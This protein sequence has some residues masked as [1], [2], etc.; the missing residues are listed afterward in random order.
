MFEASYARVYGV[1]T[2]VLTVLALLPHEERGLSVWNVTSRDANVASLGRSSV[3][4]TLV[5][6]V[7]LL[8]LTVR[9]GT[10]AAPGWTL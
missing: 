4:L 10:S 3:F 1:L 5:L 9:P 6:A 2:A 8:A 7:I